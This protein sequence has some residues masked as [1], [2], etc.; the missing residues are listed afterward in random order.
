MTA[1]Q[2]DKQVNFKT[3]GAVWLEAQKVFA[4]KEMDGTS[5]LN[6]FLQFVATNK[7]LPFLTDEEQEREILVAK[8]QER[9]K[10]NMESETI[11][12]EELEK[13]LG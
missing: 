9:V 12:F 8:L 3:N 4:E 1:L 6:Y 10:K 5:A 13:R 2:K 7:K 11:S